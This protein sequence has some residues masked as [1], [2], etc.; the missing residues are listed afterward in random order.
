M[1]LEHIGVYRLY[2][3]ALNLDMFNEG[4]LR[5]MD[6]C[7]ECLQVFKALTQC[8]NQARREFLVYRLLNGPENNGEVTV[9]S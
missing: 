2:E 9:K 8:N 6:G 4:D 7:T 1:E 3:L 5:H